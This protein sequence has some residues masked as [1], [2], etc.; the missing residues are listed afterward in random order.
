METFPGA[1]IHSFRIFLTVK[2]Q[3]IQVGIVAVVVPPTAF[4]LQGTVLVPFVIISIL[5]GKP[6]ATMITKRISSGAYKTK[7]NTENKLVCLRETS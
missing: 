7:Q 3:A 6:L 5:G 1:P 4:K 2:V